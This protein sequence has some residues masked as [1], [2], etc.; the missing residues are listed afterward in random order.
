MKYKK[1]YGTLIIS[2]L[3]I[4]VADAQ[5]QQDDTSGQSVMGVADVQAKQGDISGQSVVGV[6]NELKIE[7]ET[8]FKGNTTYP[9][10]AIREENINITIT[11]L[12]KGDYVVAEGNDYYKKIYKST[13]VK[14]KVNITYN[15]RYQGVYKITV[16]DKKGN[17][18]QERELYV[19]P[20]SDS[21]E[22]YYQLAD[23]NTI[24]G[25]LNT[26]EGQQLVEFSTQLESAQKRY[27]DEIAKKRYT[28]A[29]TIG[30]SNMPSK[31]I[32]NEPGKEGSTIKEGEDFNLGTGTYE[33]VASVKNIHSL[34]P[35]NIKLTNYT[36][37]NPKGS[38]LTATMNVDENGTYTINAT[39]ED[40]DEQELI[41]AFLITDY[42][43]T[44]VV[45][46]YS[47][48]NSYTLPKE[49]KWDCTVTGRVKHKSRID[50]ITDTQVGKY[51]E[52]S[53]EVGV[54]CR[55]EGNT[56]VTINAVTM[57]SSDVD[58]YMENKDVKPAW[59]GNE[60]RIEFSN[61]IQTNVLNAIAREKNY[62]T[63]EASSQ[64]GFDLVYKAWV[65]E[66]GHYSLLR[67]YNESNEFVF[68]PFIGWEE[69]KEQTLLISVQEKKD[70]KIM[71]GQEQYIKVNIQH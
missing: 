26:T 57:Q 14:N 62:F 52:N 56:S 65:I 35:Q 55:K 7:T 30:E 63:V 29:Y 69:S 43:G 54:S 67:D 21:T 70:G 11:G 20:A 32:L 42:T 24:G 23:I 19:K 13:E 60:Q 48:D 4:G 33:V 51:I 34:E 59:M 38:K 47:S 31:R 27:K 61:R 10:L 6:I 40:G 68:Y 9:I 58:E 46:N 45:Q 12:N 25:E 17:I 16:R 1:F 49:Y 66:D 37:E 5:G 3:V 41:Y 22:Y 18:R 50:E 28:M 64:Q 15:P 39:R 36:R 71:G 8:D 2:L 53:Y 44:H